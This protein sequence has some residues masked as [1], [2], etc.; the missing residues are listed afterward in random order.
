MQREHISSK[1]AG[2]NPNFSP[3]DSCVEISG[4]VYQKQYLEEPDDPRESYTETLLTK[5][6]TETHSSNK[7][8]EVLYQDDSISLNIVKSANDSGSKN[9]VVDSP[10][11]D[12]PIIVEPS[13]EPFAHTESHTTPAPTPVKN[14]MII[15]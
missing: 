13:V 8:K 3:S 15:S 11:S 4:S 9:D 14:S 12:D 1:Q 10:Q 6:V 2:E 5:S 7:N